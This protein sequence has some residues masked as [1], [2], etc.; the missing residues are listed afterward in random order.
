MVLLEVCFYFLVIIPTCGNTKQWAWHTVFFIFV[1]LSV[2]LY[3]LF[4]L[5]IC[6]YQQETPETL[7]LT[8]TQMED[9]IDVLSG[10]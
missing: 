10:T 5:L 1:Y 7:L 9:G 2:G 3:S 4:F 8:W 6:D